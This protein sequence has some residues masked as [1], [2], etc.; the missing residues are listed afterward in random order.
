MRKCIIIQI[1]VNIFINISLMRITSIITS[2]AII[3]NTT[4]LVVLL[5]FAQQLKP[6]TFDPPIREIASAIKKLLDAVSEVSQY[7]P[8]TQGKQS[9]EHRKRDFVKHSKKFS[10]TLKEYFKEGQ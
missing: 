8:G 2:V 1:N 7:I 3:P 6:L 4:A 9:L 5:T 10:N